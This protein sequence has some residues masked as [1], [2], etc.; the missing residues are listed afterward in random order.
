MNLS[1]NKKF[2]LYIIAGIW[3]TF[4]GYLLYAIFTYFF[5][6]YG[7]RFS[8]MLAYVIGNAIS[9][10]QAFVVHKYLVFKSRGNFLREYKKCWLVYGSTML[11]SLVLLPIFVKVAHVFLPSIYVHF[12][13]Y[14]GGIIST[15]LVAI[16]SYL[17]HEKITFKNKT[18]SQ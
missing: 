10:T 13:K 7:I 11:L 3:N 16:I 6:L 1:I 8:Y 9:I 17:G 18:C 12:D 14:I 15:G 4:F 2:I 5:D